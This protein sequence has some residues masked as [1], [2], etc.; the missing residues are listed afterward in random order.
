MRA[1]PAIKHRVNS[2]SVHEPFVFTPGVSSSA[3]TGTQS[4]VEETRRE[5]AEIVREVAEAVHV[6]QSEPEFLSFLIDRVLRAMA[7]EGVIVWK[8][9]ERSSSC[10]EAVSRAGKL[11]D[12]TIPSVSIATHQNLI[13]EVASTGQPVVVPPTPGLQDTTAIA[14]PTDTPAALVPITSDPDATDADFVLEVFLEPDCGVAAQRGYL[15]FVAQMADLAGE[16][17]RV[18]RVR[19]LQQQQLLAKKVD[20]AIE[21]FPLSADLSEIEAA[22]VDRAAEL[23]AFDRVGLCIGTPAK[24]KS[25]SHV[26]R[27]DQRSPAADQLREATALPLDDDFVWPSAREVNQ[28]S[29]NDRGVDG[30]SEMQVR[31]CAG[32][33]AD[34]SFR[35]VCIQSI[36]SRSLSKTMRCELRRFAVHAEFAYRHIRQRESRLG[37]LSFRRSERGY[38]RTLIPATIVFITV[39]ALAFVP[40]PLVVHGNAFLRPASAQRVIATR[41]AQVDQI[42]VQH[43]E[44]VR[45][46]Q[47]LVTLTDPILEAEIASLR[48]Q[49]AV[50]M[51][52]RTQLTDEIVDTSTR[53]LDRLDELQGRREVIAAE[54]RTVEQQLDILQQTKDN[55]VLRSHTDGIVD[56]WQV[57][58][59]LQSRPLKRGDAL[60]QIISSDSGWIADTRVAQHRVGHLERAGEASEIQ[61]RVTLLS[62]PDRALTATISQIGPSLQSD[63]GEPGET[64]VLLQ[65]ENLESAPFGTD[66]LTD[67]H[68]GAPAKVIFH[69]GSAPAV[70]CLFQD[71]YRSVRC[72]LTLHG[73]LADSRKGNTL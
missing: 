57:E 39:A 26:N 71:L 70:Y 48:G 24:L 68:S 58:R 46:G 16:F 56:A 6:D 52:E 14:N 1:Q 23:F 10:L 51:Q 45:P 44:A 53:E 12:L 49:Q 63:S 22:I 40:V 27:I 72:K 17:L 61:V 28:E 34:P 4:L 2:A 36:E 20:E 43:G 18:D 33:P 67:H 41:D 60:M 59:V 38:R 66:A 13:C 30:E 37:W 64:A 69:C 29:N 8:R 54:L 31:A 50:L 3:A 65:V 21:Q 32:C 15:R 7:A 73:V 9:F 19:Q 62:Q 5:I 35:L 11:T 55:L 47:R 42:H 25:V